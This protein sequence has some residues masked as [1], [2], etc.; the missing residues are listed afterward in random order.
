VIVDVPARVAGAVTIG[1]IHV[2]YQVFGDQLRAVLLLP[3]WS[4][5]HSAVW[6]HQVQRLA[7]RY[8]VVTFDGRGNGASDRPLDPSNYTDDVSAADALAVLDAAGIDE[9]AMVSV[10]G[11]TRVGLA[12]AARH[13]DRVPAAIFI[14]PSLPITPPIPEFGHAVSVFD[15]PQAAYEGWLKFNR[16]YWQQDWPGFLGFFMGR[17]LTEPDS[18]VQVS[19][20]AEM[21]LQTT[22]AVITA[23][24][25]A[26]GFGHDEILDFAT[27]VS[28]P[29]LVIHGAADAVSPVERGHELARLSQ[30]E[31]ITL[32]GSGHQPQYRDPELVN[33]PMLQFLD[34]HYPTA[35][36]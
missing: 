21:G 22:A 13:P 17:C 8:T 31:L 16:H 6:R 25:D 5:C 34:R 29:W 32:P 19:E 36:R 35:S 27:S 18:A 20:Y 26:P 4:I 3:P 1:G 9:A 2:T 33:R 30:A 28:R 24:A 11:A 10:S 12:L 15:E 7:E 23:T 14:A